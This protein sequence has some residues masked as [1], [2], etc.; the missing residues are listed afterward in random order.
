MELVG[1]LPPSVASI[2]VFLAM[3]AKAHDNH[4]KWNEQAMFKVN[5]MNL[6][7]RWWSVDAVAFRSK[8]LA[9]GMQSE[10]VGYWSTGSRKPKLVGGSYPRG[11]TERFASIHRPGKPR[12]PPTSTTEGDSLEGSRFVQIGQVPR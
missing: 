11:P 1:G 6:R 10:D 7:H 5:L 9:E 4:L 3:Q 2:A 8:S 12:F